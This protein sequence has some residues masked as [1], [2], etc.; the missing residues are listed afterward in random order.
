VPFTVTVSSPARVP[1]LG[2]YPPEYAFDAECRYASRLALI[3]G[4]L[5]GR[6]LS[7]DVPLDAVSE[8]TEGSDMNRDAATKLRRTPSLMNGGEGL[9]AE[10][11]AREKM[12]FAVSLGMFP[13]RGG[14]LDEMMRRELFVSRATV[15]AEMFIFGSQTS[16]DASGGV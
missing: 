11:R 2:R 6:I 9:V 7:G 3:A 8:L 15:T 14:R 16:T 1:Y 5:S 10:R 12:R 4:K 13:M